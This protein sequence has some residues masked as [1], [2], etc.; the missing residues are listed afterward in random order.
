[1]KNIIYLFKLK[2]KI[3]IYRTQ[4]YLIVI[5]IINLLVGL[6]KSMTKR[7]SKFKSIY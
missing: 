2:E 5:S 7:K 3:D 4:T 6:K 1:M